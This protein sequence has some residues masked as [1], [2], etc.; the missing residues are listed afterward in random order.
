LG[1]SYSGPMW[2]LGPAMSKTGTYIWDSNLECLLKISDNIP[3][4]SA[5][6]TFRGAEEVLD[7]DDYPIVVRSKKQKQMELRKR[8]LVE[9]LPGEKVPKKE[10]KKDWSKLTQILEK[11]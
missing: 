6:V 5:D 9:I 4:V 2:G 10:K 7:I 11:L 1:G 8:N 3:N